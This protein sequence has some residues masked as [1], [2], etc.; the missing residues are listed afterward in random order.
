[1]FFNKSSKQALAQCQLQLSKQLA[2]VQAIEQSLACV[3]FTPDGTVI[4]AN[5]LFAELFGLEHEKLKG[6]PHK[7]LCQADYAASTQYRSFWEQLRQG[8]AAAGVF[9]RRHADGSSIYLQATYFPVFEQGKV[10]RVMKIAADVTNSQMETDTQK[11]VA[12][13]L[14]NSQAII[15]FD[16]KGNIIEA[17]ANFLDV[18]G[19]TRAELKGQHHKLFCDEAFYREHPHF[20]E[21]LNK[22]QFK[23]GLFKRFNKLGQTVWLEAS[24]NPIRNPAGKVIKVI[25]FAS[26]ITAR[27]EKSQA[28]KEAAEIAHS[29]ALNTG[30]TVEQAID[31]LDRVTATSNS[32]ASQVQQASEAIAQLN[33]QSRNIQAIVS[34]ISAIAEQTNLLALNAAIEAA[35]A[36]E[37][38]RGFAVVAD[39]V[40]QLAART[41]E[42]T[43]E[44]GSVVSQNGQLTDKATREMA[45]VAEAANQGKTQLQEVADVMGAI[46]DGARNVVDNVASL[47]D[48]HHGH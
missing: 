27:I 6:M 35:R 43:K 21:E 46:L 7:T 48:E 40:R 4:E 15:E 22:G 18:M 20:W 38:G 13:A 10:T 39:E 28:I 33:E 12:N 36:G 47:S 25:K 14:D 3:V 1:M 8:K 30:A 37:Q 26:D 29:T 41:S 34:T 31:R 5:R 23:S 44:I 32:I 2:T 11:A 45:A 19:Y 24:Y 16:P 9:E 42:S 17:N